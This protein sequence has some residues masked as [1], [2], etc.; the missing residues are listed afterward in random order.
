MAHSTTPTVGQPE[1][2]VIVLPDRVSIGEA[3]EIHR[4]LREASGRGGPIAI[5]GS[6]VM[7]IDTAGLQ[8]LT[9][10]WRSGTAGA[11]MCEWRAVSESLIRSARLIG[12][13]GPLRLSGN[14][15]GIRS[16]V[17]N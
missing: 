7:E 4:I 1:S 8:L 3:A 12:L 15:P 10:L 2:V 11:D 6:K 5:D 16:D 14:N 17:P 9:S 13:D